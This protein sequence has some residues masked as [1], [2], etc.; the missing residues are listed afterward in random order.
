MCVKAEKHIL[1]KY[2]VTAKTGLFGG[3]SKVEIVDKVQT[4]RGKFEKIK[5]QLKLKQKEK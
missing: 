1:W 5:M 2:R 3:L 4:E